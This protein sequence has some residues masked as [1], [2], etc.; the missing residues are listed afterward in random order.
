MNCPWCNSKSVDHTG[1]FDL[2]NNEAR[3]DYK[4]SDCGCGFQVTYTS[5]HV[6]MVKPPENIRREV[7]GTVK[8]KVTEGRSNTLRDTLVRIFI[9]D[10][11]DYGYWF[12][13]RSLYQMLD[14]KQ[15]YQY[16]EPAVFERGAYRHTYVDF[17]VSARD[18]DIIK[19]EGLN[20]FKSGKN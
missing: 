13:E 4:C 12:S 5:P 11:H 18:A 15:R 14:A 17:T 20:P 16:L 10:G 19:K 7:P 2:D 1:E 6:F 3:H 8:I 9:K